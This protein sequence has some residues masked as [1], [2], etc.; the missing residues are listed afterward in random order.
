MINNPIVSFSSSR[1][2]TEFILLRNSFVFFNSVRNWGHETI[3]CL[4]LSLSTYRSYRR[5]KK[6]MSPNGMC[7]VL[8]SH[9]VASCP[10]EKN[11]LGVCNKLYFYLIPFEVTYPLGLI[12]KISS[13]FC[14]VS[15]NRSNFIQTD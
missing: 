4:G 15:R 9:H 12:Q 11:S 5:V 10:I 2:Q 6:T 7:R 13:F 1:R 14:G 3:R 8:V